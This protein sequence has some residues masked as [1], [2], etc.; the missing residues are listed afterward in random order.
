MSRTMCPSCRSIMSRAWATALASPAASR[1]TWRPL[2]SGASGFRSSW[3]SSARNSSL[4]RSCSR[5]ASSIRRRSVMSVPVAATNR[6]R[7]ASSVTGARMRSTIRSATVGHEVVGLRAE[8]PPAGRL[9]AGRPDHVHQGRRPVPPPALP[10]RLADDL[11]A[12]EP[13]GVEAEPVRLDDRAVEG[14]DA[15]EV[16]PLLE[17]GPE[18][19]VRL[20]RLSR[21]RR[22][23]PVALLALPQGI[24]GALPLGDVAG[25]LRRPDDAA[26]VVADRR[27]RQGDVEAAAVLGHADRLEVLDPL[28]AAE[29]LQDRALLVDA[30]PAG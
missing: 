23:P 12:G 21:L 18:L 27:D 5:S 6:T 3:A 19:G 22:R 2:R 11:L 15:G 8:Q 9:E 4:R 1:I 30:A 29:P 26:R 7:P 20:G 16:R 17:E 28:P 13:A 10:E 24:L 14:Q 25:D